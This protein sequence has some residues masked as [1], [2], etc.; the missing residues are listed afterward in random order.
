MIGR[1]IEALEKRVDV[2]EKWSA[3]RVS[4]PPEWKQWEERQQHG[5]AESAKAAQERIISLTRLTESQKRRECEANDRDVAYR[6]R[7]AELEAERDRL[8]AH[9][10]HIRECVA[11]GL[12]P[13]AL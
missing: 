5:S 10:E 13:P 3:I 12:T 11:H 1:R 6:K 2:L 7:I 8:A 4:R 9:L